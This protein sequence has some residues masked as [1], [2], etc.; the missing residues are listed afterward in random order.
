MSI[1]L[2]LVETLTSIHFSYFYPFQFPFKPQDF[3]SYV[4]FP[5]Q[6]PFKPKNLPVQL[7]PPL[8]RHDVSR[9][10][11]IHLLQRQ[12]LLVQRIGDPPSIRAL[13]GGQPVVAKKMERKADGNG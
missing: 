11:A 6:L 5:I 2:L 12:Q 8:R 13:V 10:A 7:P 9:P 4:H 3:I 1:H